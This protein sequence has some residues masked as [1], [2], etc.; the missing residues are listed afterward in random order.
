MKSIIAEG[1]SIVKAIEKAWIAAGKP[2]E[3][4]IKIFEEQKRNFIGMTTQAAKVGL[5][6]AQQK[7]EVVSE[8]PKLRKPLKRF[9]E[10]PQKSMQDSAQE[11]Q[12]ARKQTH[13]IWSDEM[14]VEAQ[15]WLNQILQTLNRSDVSFQTATNNYQLRFNFNQPILQDIE[16]ERNLFRSLSFLMLQ[17]LKRKFK[18]P[19]RGFKIVLTRIV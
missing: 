14:I 13:E 12:F 17:T 16:Q 8:Q 10:H 9:P 3:F 1:S 2:T 6:F 7:H 15:R 11:Q 19:L 4:S 18:R 5:F